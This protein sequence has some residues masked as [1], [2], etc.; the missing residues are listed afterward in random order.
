MIGRKKHRY[1]MRCVGILISIVMLIAA[2]ETSADEHM[3]HFVHSIAGIDIWENEWSGDDNCT[4][5]P[6]KSCTFHSGFNLASRDSVPPFQTK[7]AIR[8]CIEKI[9]TAQKLLVD[10]PPPKLV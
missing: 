4:P 10:P 8:I 7:L 5:T 2:V 3:S 1:L 6:F 9:P